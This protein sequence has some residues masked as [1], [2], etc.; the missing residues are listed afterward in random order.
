[1]ATDTV[2]TPLLAETIEPDDPTPAVH[3]NIGSTPTTTSRTAPVVLTPTDR[4]TPNVN[5]TPSQLEAGELE[6]A[7]S[8]FLVLS[9]L[10]R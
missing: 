7:V 9:V 5:A 8:A 2:K 10:T 1:M 3:G 4:A 6:F